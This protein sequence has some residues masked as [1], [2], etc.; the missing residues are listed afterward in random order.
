MHGYMCACVWQWWLAAA[1]VLLTWRQPL[2]RQSR[3]AACS[4]CVKPPSA[5]ELAKDPKKADTFRRDQRGIFVKRFD[6]VPVADVEIVFPDKE[7]GLKLIDQL[8]LYGTAVAALIG[9]IMAFLGGSIELSVIMSTM[10]VMGGKLFQ[11]RGGRSL[12]AVRGTCCLLIC[13][14]CVVDASSQ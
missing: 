3:A 11:V 2:R 12:W 1:R 14:V 7:I 13:M 8:T 9:G 4:K 10:T 5:A 6:E